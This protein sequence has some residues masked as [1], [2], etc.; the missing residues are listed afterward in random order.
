MS[1]RQTSAAEQV[2]TASIKTGLRQHT[3]SISLG[4]EAALSWFFGQGL[5]IYDRSTF[6]AIINK[7]AMD[8]FTS[9]PCERCDGAGILETGGFTVSDECRACKGEGKSGAGKWCSSCGG[10]GKV[11]AYETAVANGGW[12]FGCRGSGSGAIEKRAQ[13]RTRCTICLS[14]RGDAECRNCAHCLGT[15][16][17]PLSARPKPQQDGGSGVQPDD[18]ALTRFAITS[19]RVSA[20]RAQS[21]ALAHALSVYYGDAGQRWGLTDHGRI[22]SLYH[23]TPSG[24][25]LAKWGEKTGN[26]DDLGLTAQE[27]IGTQ[28]ALE[29]GQPKRERAALLEG[30]GKQSKDLYERAATAWN[31]QSESNA[32]RHKDAMTGLALTLKR[33][34]HTAIAADI[35]AHARALP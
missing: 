28:A 19:R 29:A 16:H 35:R 27:R 25:K 6:G 18:S 7:L 9:A 15:G 3:N 5:S 14:K 32:K 2:S 31:S 21:P 1:I 17:E 26:Q 12:C 24:K 8:A 30:A 11:D 34:G 22:F 23:L 33:L 20:V 10:Y 4:D 13:R